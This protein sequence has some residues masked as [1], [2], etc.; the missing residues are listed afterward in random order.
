MLNENYFSH[1]DRRE[2]EAT[3]LEI[4]MAVIYEWIVRDQS[5]PEELL[6]VYVSPQ[7]D[8]TID[9]ACSCSRGTADQTCPHALRVINEIKDDVILI[10]Q[11]FKPK[12]SRAA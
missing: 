3:P 12:Q 1:N 10:A 6:V 8:G 11:L 9:A 5:L 7:P 4:E 2:L